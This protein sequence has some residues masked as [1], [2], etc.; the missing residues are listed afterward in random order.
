MNAVRTIA[1]IA[2]D[3]IKAMLIVVYCVCADIYERMTQ[4][5]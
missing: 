1:E 5:K 3:L 4:T 2:F